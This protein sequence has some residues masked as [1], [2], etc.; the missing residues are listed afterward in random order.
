M[1][2]QGASFLKVD[3]ISWSPNLNC[4]I[5]SRGTGKSTLL[6]YLRLALDRLRDGDLPDDLREE[7]NA[8][9]HDT[10]PQDAQVEVALKKPEGEYR[11]VYS[12]GQRQVFVTGADAPNPNLDARALFPFRILSQREIDHSVDRRD[13]KA[14]LRI[15]DDFIHPELDALAAETER[16]RGRIGEIEAALNTRHEAQ[17]RRAALETENQGIERRLGNLEG[18]CE[19]LQR[20]QGVEAEQRFFEG[21]FEEAEQVLQTWRERLEDLELQATILTADLK[22]SPNA[23]LVA[24]AAELADQ[25]ADRLR[26]A[27]ETALGDFERTMIGD[28]APLHQLYRQRWLPLFGH[29]QQAFEQAQQEAQADGVEPAEIEQLRRRSGELKTELAVLQQQAEEIEELEGQRQEVLAE[30]RRVWQEQ[31]K[32]RQRK[33]EELMQVLR[34]R[35]GAKPLVEIQVAHQGDLD[36]AVEILAARIP[37]RR[38]INEQDIETLVKHLT[39]QPGTAQPSAVMDR[40][41]AEARAATASLVLQRVFQDRRRDAFLEAYTESVLRALEVERIPDRI[42]YLVYRQ[43]GTLAGPIERVSAGQQGTAILYLLLAG[44]KEPLVVDTPEEGLDNEGVYLELVPLFRR[45]KEHRQI[46]VV[47]HNANIPVN[48]DAELIVA[49]DAIGVVPEKTLAE[50]V[51]RHAQP[52]NGDQLRHL[53]ELVLRKDWE[54]AVRGYLGERQHW[55]DLVVEQVILAI[56]SQRQAEGRIKHLQTASQSK[57]EPAVGALDVPSVKRAVQD[58][59][60]GSEEA[61]RRRREKYGF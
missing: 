45:E 27:I 60:E 10:L 23:T 53:A 3:P 19:P 29:E 38:R 1:S 14:L 39:E 44:G 28:D 52:L 6:D 40:F 56:G 33:A 59:M 5:G 8:R 55:S 22:R 34:P 43:D 48:A 41:V 51:Q 37:D 57:G 31:T 9:I 17:K 13:R 25:A 24:E 15:L 30:L 2:V 50:I 36:E 46:L 21:L 42:T 47:T 18:L 11:V 58:I 49:L 35:P 4:L 61:F 16:L 26:A 32:A 12:S 7:I 20:W 54:D